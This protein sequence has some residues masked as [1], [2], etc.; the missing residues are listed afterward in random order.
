M[1]RVVFFGTSAFGADVLRALAA[2]AAADP[3]FA[4]QMRESFLERRRAAL[5]QLL[6]RGVTRG[7]LSE[8]QSAA[9]LDLVYGSLWY[10]LIFAV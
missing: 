1:K 5:R 10:R 8:A 3:A 4:A 6:E 2:E 7:E 9:A